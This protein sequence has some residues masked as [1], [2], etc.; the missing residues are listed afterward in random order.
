MSIWVGWAQ[1]DIRNQLQP[2]NTLTED[3]NGE[4]TLRERDTHERFDVTF[5][6]GWMYVEPNEAWVV[7]ALQVNADHYMK[8]RKE[9]FSTGPYKGY[10]DR[11]WRQRKQNR[12]NQVEDLRTEVQRLEASLRQGKD[13]VVEARKD[14]DFQRLRASEA[15]ANADAMRAE[16][17][18]ALQRVKELEGKVSFGFQTSGNDAADLEK[19]ERLLKLHDTARGILQG[20][21]RSLKCKLAADAKQSAAS[22]KDDEGVDGGPP[23]KRGTDGV[24]AGP[25][26]D[27]SPKKM[28][29]RSTDGVDA[30]PPSNKKPAKLV[31]QSKSGERSTGDCK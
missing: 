2:F 25:P 9:A 12:S 31:N 19:A 21:I 5:D 22:R 13:D 15:R 16:R 20:A 23:S 1:Y 24:D 17:D 3:L 8:A 30:G 4:V 11:F 7:E 10:F 28:V 27:L 6:N 18:E 14:A 29:K 26:S